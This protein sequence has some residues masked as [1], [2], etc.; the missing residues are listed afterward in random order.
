M[1]LDDADVFFDGCFDTAGL[2]NSEAVRIIVEENPAPSSDGFQPRPGRWARI[3]V[4]VSELDY[5]PAVHD[6]VTDED[7]T[8]WDV[9]QVTREG[10]VCSLLCIAEQRHRTK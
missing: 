4:R 8:E 3:F 10:S 2:Y 5:T 6:K 7:E 9:Q 1:T